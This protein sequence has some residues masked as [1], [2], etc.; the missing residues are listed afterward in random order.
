MNNCKDTNQAIPDRNL[1][2]YSGIEQLMLCWTDLK[3]GYNNNNRTF[4]YLSLKIC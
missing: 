4:M 2:V 3:K 1:L